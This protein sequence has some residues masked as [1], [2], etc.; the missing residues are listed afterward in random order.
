M[1]LIPT[2]TLKHALEYEVTRKPEPTLKLWT[3]KEA[4]RWE[5]ERAKWGRK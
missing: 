2:L 3:I 5:V 1:Q 4:L